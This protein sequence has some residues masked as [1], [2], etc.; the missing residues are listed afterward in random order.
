MKP[1]SIFGIFGALGAAALLAAYTAHAAPDTATNDMDHA[2][3]N[4]ISN[5]T[6]MQ[7]KVMKTDDE[8]KKELT[9][10]QYDVMRKKGTERPFTGKYWDT[11][12]PGVYHCAACGAVLFLSQD[13]FDSG[14]GWPSFSAPASSTAV[15]T[16]DDN[17][18]FMHRTEVVCPV[19]GAHLGH[20]FDDGPAPTGLRYCI[21]SAS[22]KLEP[23]D[24]SSK[25]NKP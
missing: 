14:C 1:I 24:N 21:N 23:M 9:P 19:C 20:V 3:I 2:M 13:K 18:Y 6:P 10:E 11:K 5:T 17:S 16:D 22:I 12:T 15:A 25:T 4:T 8:W 7:Y